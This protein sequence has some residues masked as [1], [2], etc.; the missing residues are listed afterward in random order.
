[1]QIGEEHLAGTHPG[2]LGRQRLLDLEDHL[3]LGPHGLD[4]IQRGARRRV[5][6]V[7]D[8]AALPRPAL[9]EN[10]M[11]GLGKGAS[12]GGGERHPLLAGLD[13]PGYAH[14]HVPSLL[15][16]MRACGRGF[17]RR[18]PIARSGPRAG[19]ARAARY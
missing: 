4:R 18:R 5:V 16:V 6:L 19:A 8:A 13:L 12:A 7:A 1:M 15:R 10:A 14:D 3:G 11:P 2:V 17:P 9:D